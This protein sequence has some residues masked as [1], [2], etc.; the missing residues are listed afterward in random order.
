MTVAPWVER[1]RSAFGVL[2][3]DVE[4]ALEHLGVG[5]GQHGLDFICAVDRRAVARILPSSRRRSGFRSDRL[6]C[7][8]GARSAGLWMMTES[9]QLIWRRLR[10][11]SME[12]RTCAALKSTRPY[13]A[14]Q[15]RVHYN[16]ITVERLEN[17][18]QPLLAR[19]VPVVRGGVEEVDAAVE[20]RTDH[21]VCIGLE[22]A[23]HPDS[24]PS[25]HAPKPSSETGMP[26]AR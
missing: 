18:A 14:G 20:G 12:P 11:R 1:C 9:M 7:R 13:R 17:L 4:E 26:P 16:R 19:A 25:C 15:F 24:T 23:L 10:L 6:C 21:A 3:Q 8:Q 2:V 22:T 5:G